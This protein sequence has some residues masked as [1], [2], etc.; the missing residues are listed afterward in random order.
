MGDNLPPGVSV[1]DLP[2]NR[3]SDEP[4]ERPMR[5]ECAVCGTPVPAHLPPHKDPDTPRFCENHDGDDLREQKVWGPQ[6]SFERGNRRP[7]PD[8]R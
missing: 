8:S 2:G 6:R 1:S 4:K 3:P 5:G 7:G